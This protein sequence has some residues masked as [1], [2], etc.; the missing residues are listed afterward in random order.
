MCSGICTPSGCY[1]SDSGAFLRQLISC[2]IDELQVFKFSTVQC[3]C[4]SFV[5]HF[6]IFVAAIFTINSR[7]KGGTCSYHSSPCAV[8]RL[9]ESKASDTHFSYELLTMSPP[10]LRR[11]HDRCCG[12][13]LSLQR[14]WRGGK[15]RLLCCRL[16]GCLKKPASSG[17]HSGSQRG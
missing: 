12:Y 9:M 11:I 8:A 10:L 2:I 5:R 16:P 13:L 3:C 15:C 6:S 7:Q 17:L 14:R 1:W 4:F